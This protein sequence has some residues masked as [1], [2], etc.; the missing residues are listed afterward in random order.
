M[1]SDLIKMLAEQAQ[2]EAEARSAYLQLSFTASR[3]GY[4]GIAKFF[5]KQA[6]EEGHHH[7]KFLRLLDEYADEMV[8]VPPIDAPET[9]A[10]SLLEAMTMALEME[11][12]VRDRINAITTCAL[13]CGSHEI[14]AWLGYFHEIQ[15]ESV[16]EFRTLVRQFQ[17][18]EHDAGALFA[19]D[20]RLG[21]E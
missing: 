10:T 5:R 2:V 6:K 15:V 4:D 11:C 18:A 16:K 9:Q 14:V 17:E 12:F 8:Q 3:M 19:L 7:R 1:N 20:K 21:K 13:Q